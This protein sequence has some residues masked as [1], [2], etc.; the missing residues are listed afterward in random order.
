MIAENEITRRNI[1]KSVAGVGVGLTLGSFASTACAS[2]PAGEKSLEP[3]AFVR[4]D[5][6]GT[7]TVTISKP[8]MGQGVRTSLAMLVA[9]ELD[10]DWKQVKVVQAMADPDKYGGQVVGGSSSVRSM[11]GNMRRMGAAARAMLVQAAASQWKVEATACK[12]Q[13][14]FVISPGGEKLAYG[15][16]APV[17][18]ELSVPNE[19][20]LKDKADFK[21]I[22]KPT[23]GVDAKDVVTGRAKF[24]LDIK[25]KDM[26]YATVVRKPWN[27]ATIQSYDDQEAQKTPGVQKIIRNGDY[28]AVIGSNS[29]AAISGRKK[30]KITWSNGPADVS[31]PKLRAALK[32]AIGPHKTMQAGAKTAKAEFELPYLAHGTMEPM[33][34]TVWMQGNRCEVWAPSQAPDGARTQ[35]ARSLGLSE[36]QVEFHVTLLGGG[37]G[38]RFSTDFVMQAVQIAKQFDNPIQLI[39]TREDDMRNDLYRPMSHHALL[40]AVDDSGAPVGWSHQAVDAGGSRR[41]EFGGAGINYQIPDAAMSRSATPSPIPTGAWRS[42]ENT[43]LNVV[44]EC[45][46]DELAHLAGQDPFEYRRKHIRNDRL[47][48]VLELAAEKAGWGEK[49]PAGHGRGIACFSGYGSCAAHV[50][51]VSVK[52]GQVKVIRAVCAVDP[53]LAVNPSGVEA[54][55]QGALSDGLATGLH[56]AITVENGGIVEGNWHQYEWIRI[57]EI[58][59]VE[60]HIVESGENPGGMGEVGYPSVIPALANAIFAATGKRVRKIPIDLTELV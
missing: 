14:G 32:A 4:I 2:S 53:G 29:W 37:F 8:D 11:Y 34:A 50:I 36:D 5:P 47:K 17:A 48:R 20:P 24:G 6:D 52:D 25:L 21:L 27:G 19:F 39:W 26:L 60:V 33:N 56:A 43:Q 13:N 1:L 51:E 30:L 41:G 40:G 57:D 10:A 44:N 28:V 15:K 46:F 23:I 16:L 38:R 54:Q 35:V 22:G 59:K 3:N 49:L 45:F 18:A 12:T 42:V 9:E 7:V 31:T 58:P 55:I